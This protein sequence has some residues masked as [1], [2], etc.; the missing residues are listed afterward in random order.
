MEFDISVD[1]KTAQYLSRGIAF[2]ILGTTPLFFVVKRF[3]FVNVDISEFFWIFFGI[4]F[5]LSFLLSK[6]KLLFDGDT[7]RFVGMVPFPKLKIKISDIERAW[8]KNTNLS[9]GGSFIKTK[10]QGSAPQVSDK[11]T[12]FTK[13]RKSKEPVQ[14]K[15]RGQGTTD[16][17]ISY[18][19]SYGV[20]VQEN[21]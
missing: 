8:T 18:L 14:I 11:K 12:I 5:G 4:Y 9:T 3:G 1:K 2:L 19:Y 17:I 7:L 6:V 21:V 16:S 10:S 15:G 13:H 20:K